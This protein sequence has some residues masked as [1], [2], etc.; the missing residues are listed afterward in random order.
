MRKWDFRPG[1]SGK[2]RTHQVL[3]K[4]VSVHNGWLP[5]ITKVTQLFQLRF[6]LKC[7]EFF[8]KMYKPF[9]WRSALFWALLM[10]TH[11]MPHRSSSFVKSKNKQT[12]VP[13]KCI[14]LEKAIHSNKCFQRNT[15][16]R[17]HLG[18]FFNSLESIF[19]DIFCLLIKIILD[20]CKI[21]EK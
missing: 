5:L 12:W 14:Q 11:S 18:Y 17:I 15:R 19:T 16:W 8:H 10:K 20:C 6:P 9:I 3:Q 2:L 4:W 21:F 7:R 13:F 1:S